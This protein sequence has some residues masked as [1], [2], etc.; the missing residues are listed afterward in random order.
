MNKNISYYKGVMLWQLGPPITEKSF[1]W[2][3]YTYA[4]VC[5]WSARQL[6]KLG[7]C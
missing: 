6:T 4:D 2:L 1:I 5:S 3:N 7:A